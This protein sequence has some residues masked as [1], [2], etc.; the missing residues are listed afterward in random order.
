MLNEVT[1]ITSGNKEISLVGTAHV[2]KESIE[3][4]RKTIDKENPDIIAVELDEQRYEALLNKKKWDETEIHKV[5]RTGRAYLF[6]TQLLLTNFQR[7]IGDKL[8]VS[9]G[10][11]MIEAINIAR[12]KGIDISL[13]D[14]DIKITLKRALNTMTL[15]EKLKLLYALLEGI[16]EREEIDDEILEKLKKKES[17]GGGI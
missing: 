7:R 17:A 12:E 2:S 6:L 10:S 8:G 3:L 4:V 1:T 16:L 9:P 14:R 5:I 13:V 11:E 15:K